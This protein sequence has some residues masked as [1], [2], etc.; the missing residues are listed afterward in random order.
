[1]TPESSA[2]AWPVAVFAHNEQKRITASLE[3]IE[4]AAAGHPVE[5]YVLANGCTDETEARVREYSRTH[6]AIHLVSIGRGDKANAWNEYVHRHLPAGADCSF[7]IDGDVRAEAG[8]FQRLYDALA[9]APHAVVSSAVPRTGRNR[10]QFERLIVADREVAGNL[11]CIRGTFLDRLRAG[12]V[13]L[14]VG[15][16]GEDGW[17]GAFAKSDLDPHRP[18]DDM[19]VEPCPTAGFFFD[20]ISLS[21]SGAIKYWQRLKRY[22]LR[23]FQNCMLGHLLK[24]QGMAHMPADVNELYRHYAGVCT[25]RWRGLNTVSDVLV[26]QQI[27][28][29]QRALLSQ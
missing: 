18:W 14:P 5:V 21:P 20:S 3:S 23:D 10:E 28:R 9:R 24:N 8:A 22:S 2:A 16:I 27:R 13:Y 15:L 1:M 7:F 11:Y 25:L 4:H 26:L 12:K 19:R 29:R 17:V 6:P